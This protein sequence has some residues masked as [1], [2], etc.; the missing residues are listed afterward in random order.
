MVSKGR[1]KSERPELTPL[2]RHLAEE[3]SFTE[4]ERPRRAR[5]VGNALVVGEVV[6]IALCVVPLGPALET[7]AFGKFAGLALIATGLVVGVLGG[8]ALGRS[9]RPHP[10]PATRGQLRTS[11]IYS[12]VRHPIYLAVMLCAVGLTLF[13]GRLLGLLATLA[14]AVVL[15]LKAKLE[16]NLLYERFGWEYATYCNRVPAILPRPWRRW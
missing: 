1:T 9:L 14:L 11:G 13:S 4:T 15:I 10:I 2:Q 12:L 16:E 7:G 5:V 8:A 3:S 6:L